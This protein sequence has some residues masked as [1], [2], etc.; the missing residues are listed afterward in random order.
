MLTKLL[1]TSIVICNCCTAV[2]PFDEEDGSAI[3][4]A[5]VWPPEHSETS[6]PISSE[7][8][9]AKCAD[10]E[11]YITG[12]LFNGVAEMMEQIT[13]YSGPEPEGHDIRGGECIDEWMHV[14][15]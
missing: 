9:A 13:K 5:L 14:D 10:W 6:T 8:A 7:V 15:H 2:N 1:V 11:N 4:G 12:S 3:K